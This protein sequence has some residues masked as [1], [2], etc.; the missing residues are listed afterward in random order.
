MKSEGTRA[1]LPT[2]VLATAGFGFLNPTGIPAQSPWLRRRSYQGTSPSKV[3]NSNGVAALG[4]SHKILPWNRLGGKTGLRT[5]ATSQSQSNPVKV[6]QSSLGDFTASHP[7]NNPA[8]LLLNLPII[9]P[10]PEGPADR[11]FYRSLQPHRPAKNRISVGNEVTSFIMGLLFLIRDSL[12]RLLPHQIFIERFGL[13]FMPAP[14]LT[15]SSE[16]EGTAAPQTS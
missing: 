1:I 8:S 7:G 6:S 15:L 9:P 4:E 13:R 14:I 12:P 2:E 11:L 10:L 3:L 5:L 16:E